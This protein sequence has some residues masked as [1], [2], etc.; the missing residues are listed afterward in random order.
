MTN[1]DLLAFIYESGPCT[2]V[3]IDLEFGCGLCS[4]TFKALELA[5]ADLVDYDVESG[6]FI[7]S[8]DAWVAQS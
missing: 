6:L 3:D 5:F 4:V 1:H 2:H 8:G 7:Y